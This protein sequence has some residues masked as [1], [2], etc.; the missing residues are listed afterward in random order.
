MVVYELGL[1]NALAKAFPGAEIGGCYFHFLEALLRHV[2]SLGL[3]KRYERVTVSINGI[4]S[5]SP[6]RLWIRRL[7]SLALSAL[8]ATCPA[9]AENKKN[10]KINRPAAMFTKSSLEQYVIST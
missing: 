9:C 4:R 6:T 3:K 5:Y 8:S 7:M 2:N 10:G 1:R